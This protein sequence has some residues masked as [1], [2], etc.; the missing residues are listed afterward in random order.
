MPT[1]GYHSVLCV[2]CSLPRLPGTH[3]HH[4]SLPAPFDC[5]LWVLAP[6][7]CIWIGLLSHQAHPPCSIS[8]CLPVT[9]LHLGRF[10]LLSAL[11][12]LNLT[13]K[14]NIQEGRALPTVS[15]DP[16]SPNG[17]DSLEV[18]Q[19]GMDRGRSLWRGTWL[20]KPPRPSLNDFFFF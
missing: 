2:P 12:T 14:A 6:A 4:A 3:C 15:S 5:C 20:S 11:V 10:P 19:A 8:C 13:S 7:T 16:F 18:L 1:P 9:S 17:S